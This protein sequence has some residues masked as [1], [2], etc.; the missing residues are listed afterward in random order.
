M[1]FLILALP[2]KLTGRLYVLLE[3]PKTIL[4]MFQH[5]V[6]PKGTP[7]EHFRINSFYCLV[8]LALFHPNILT[9]IIQI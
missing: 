3:N 8:K 1:K 9:E 2:Y 5:I 4:G 7:T 6:N